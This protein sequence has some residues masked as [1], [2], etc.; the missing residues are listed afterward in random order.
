[1]PGDGQE[2]NVPAGAF[3]TVRMRRLRANPLVRQAMQQSRLHLRDL[4]LPMFVRSGVNLRQP[5]AS[6]PGQFQYSLDTFEQELRSNSALRFGGIILFGVPAYKDTSC[7]EAFSDDGLV[8]RA[9]RIAKQVAPQLLVITDVCLCEYMEH[10]HCG[11]VNK[12]SGRLDVDND[13]TL[14]LLARQAVSHARAGADIVAPSAAMDGMVGAIRQGLDASN[15][16]HIPIMSYAVKYASAFYGPFREAAQ[17]IPQFGDRRTY[18]MDPAGRAAE[19]LREVELDIAEG[20]DIIMVKPA[21]AYLDIIAR[22]ADRFP[23]MPLAT[24]NVSGEYAMIK[25]AAAQGWI[26]ERATVLES[27]TAMKRAGANLII[28]YWARDVVRWTT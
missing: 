28:S 3:P 12:N 4:I 15:F 7:K 26:D 10:G 25:A 8:Q 14:E 17:S 24:Y 6:M 18:Q 9:V 19:A 1:M 2:D 27:L 16:T 23:A 5:I 21:L 11:V 20:A 13:A 22:V